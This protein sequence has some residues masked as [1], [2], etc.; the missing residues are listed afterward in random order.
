MKAFAILFSF[1]TFLSATG[2]SSYVSLPELSGLLEGVQIPEDELTELK[3]F[4]ESNPEISVLFRGHSSISSNEISL[5]K[6]QYL[7]NEDLINYILSTS[8][9][10]DPIANK[11]PGK[12]NT[13]LIAALLAL[14]LGP[15]GVHRMY[16]GTELRVP[17][18][19]TLTLGGGLGILPLIDFFYIILS[20]D[21]GVL[22]ENGNI[23]MWGDK[24]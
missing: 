21:E 16:L 1:L 20:K 23:F 22:N 24:K 9:M 2:Q 11:E 12:E 19:Y 10:D 6:I 14:T 4:L 8:S 7:T 18:F 5:E 15:F 13:K 3:A 17:V